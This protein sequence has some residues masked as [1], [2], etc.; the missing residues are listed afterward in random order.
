MDETARLMPT[1]GDDHL[2][3]LLDRF[4]AG[5]C[6]TEEA[7]EVRTWLAGE[8]GRRE[9]LDLVDRKSVV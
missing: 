3:A 9:E 1:S 8:P 2:W 7:Q 4:L 6:A 5:E